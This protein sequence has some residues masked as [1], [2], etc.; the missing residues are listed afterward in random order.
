MI[1][2][3]PSVTAPL[4]GFSTWMAGQYRWMS[5]SKLI[6][7]QPR[8]QVP[9]APTGLD[10]FLSVM[11]EEL[12][13]FQRT[14]HK[15]PLGIVLSQMV[16]NGGDIPNEIAAWAG[17]LSEGERS[18]AVETSAPEFLAARSRSYRPLLRVLCQAKRPPF[19]IGIDF[20][21][22]SAAVPNRSNV[23]NV[24]RTAWPENAAEIPTDWIE[25]AKQFDEVWVDSGA[26]QTALRQRWMP[27]ERIRLIDNDLSG[28]KAS[29]AAVEEAVSDL[30]RRIQP[31]AAADKAGSPIQ[32]EFEGELFAGHSFSN[33]NEQLLV[34]IEK[35]P[36]VAVALRRVIHN[37]TADRLRP[38]SDKLLG[39]ASRALSRKPDI[40][41]RH[42]FPPNWARPESGRW[43]H[44][45]PWEYG[46]LPLDW[47]P[48]LR[49]KVDEVW[50][51]SNY[52]KRVY[53][54][55]GVSP[56]RST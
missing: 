17:V 14:G 46:P 3:T 10:E 44:I 40:T 23:V 18:L 2:T 37:P 16:N 5:Y 32:V 36:S 6:D 8:S 15:L 13:M 22:P 54:Q 48:H 4:G 1:C 21:L 12:A 55:S 28:S 39:M 24:L 25:R 52:V 30:E 19:A 7:L 11:Q 31:P 26:Q 45:Q 53:V 9:S 35:E 29:Q 51:P 20:G 42:A 47:L 43:V 41:I 33:V 27:P 56:D 38:R 50:A 34:E 49:D